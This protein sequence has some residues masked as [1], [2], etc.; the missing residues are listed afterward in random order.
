MTTHT[1]RRGAPTWVKW[2]AAI[3]AIGLLTGF[4]QG[5][6][7]G[8]RT[9]YENANQTAVAVATSAPAMPVTGGGWTLA[10]NRAHTTPT[11]AKQPAM[12][13]FIAVDLVM[14]NT[15]SAPQQLCGS[16]LTL[17][18]GQG[19]TFKYSAEATDDYG[20]QSLCAAINPGLKAQA[21]IIFDVP[22]DATGLVLEGIGGFKAI[23]GDVAALP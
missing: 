16:A 11:V 14:E 12:G 8:A 21:A 9:G 2:A 13:V 23:L 19:R 5:F 1:T 17:R 18:D 4:W 10:V 22:K 7:G 3:V 6:V 15:G 20:P